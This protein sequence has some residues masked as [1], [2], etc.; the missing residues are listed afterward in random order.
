[1]QDNTLSTHLSDV[2]NTDGHQL[3]F[4]DFLN[5]GLESTKEG[6]AS[7]HSNSSREVFESC[8]QEKM[9]VRELVFSP[10]KLAQTHLF[11]QASTARPQG[12]YQILNSHQGDGR[13][14]GLQKNQPTKTHQWFGFALI[15]SEGLIR[16]HPAS[17]TH[18]HTGSNHA[19]PGPPTRPPLIIY[20]YTYI[21]K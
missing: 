13:E 14:V 10:R 7:F 21:Y 19:Y 8:Q 4:N 11:L 16:K 12:H 18:T 2:L 3:T 1:M 17:C 9:R 20:L 15:L 6:E 5:Q